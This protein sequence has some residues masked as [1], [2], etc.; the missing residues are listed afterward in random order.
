MESVMTARMAAVPHHVQERPCTGTAGIVQSPTSRYLPD[1][2]S[3]PLLPLSDSMRRLRLTERTLEK[4]DSDLIRDESRLMAIK[5]FDYRFISP[6]YATIIFAEHYSN[7]YR[8][9]YRRYRD[10]FTAD[11]HTGLG[12][13]AEGILDGNAR[14]LTSLWKARQAADEAG[15]PYKMFIRLLMEKHAEKSHGKLLH[16]NQLLSEKREKHFDPAF[17]RWLEGKHIEF[18]APE[19]PH[20]KAS[21]YRAHPWQ[22][23][24]IRVLAGIINKTPGSTRH[25]TLENYLHNH[26]LIP[27]D[28]AI[29]LFG[30]ELV[31]HARPSSPWPDKVVRKLR[32]EDFNPGCAGLPHAFLDDQPPC[33]DCPARNTCVE[34]VEALTARLISRGKSME[35]KKDEKKAKA[36]ERQ[37]RCRARRKG[38]AAS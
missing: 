28:V 19:R 1:M 7:I 20:F 35:A 11:H 24:M 2:T 12:T 23:E 10:A 6:A 16:P 18:P 17:D 4:I 29:S 30:E 32:D 26:R 14:T 15:M 38:A 3:K 34:E 33:S 21:N 5:W 8:G 25:I 36:A 37:R 27:E 9:L 22:D 31:R 13:S